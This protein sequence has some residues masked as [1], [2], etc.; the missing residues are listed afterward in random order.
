MKRPLA[1]AAALLGIAF[2]TSAVLPARAG[3]APKKSAAELEKEKAMANPYPNDLGPETLDEETLKSYPK[4]AQEGYKAM[5]GTAKEKRCQACHSGAR[6]LNSRFVELSG[7]DAAV[8]AL[9][10]SN[11]ELFKDPAIWQIEGAVWNR[12]VKRMMAKPGCNIAGPE[13]KKIWE[14]LVY[15]GEHRKIG[16]NA[17]KWKAHRTK[18][19]EEFKGKF[20]ER[21]KELAAAKDL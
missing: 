4:N 20:P 18:L 15:D 10:K 1:L 9:K 12:Y 13:G 5:M 8:A 7:K 14:F 3:D 11:P 2:L 17:D 16:A 6:P 21:Y 19:I